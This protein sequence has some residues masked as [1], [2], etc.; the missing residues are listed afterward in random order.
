MN[1]N[2]FA[3]VATIFVLGLPL[4]GLVGCKG[5]CD[6]TANDSVSPLG[7][8]G[9][10]AARPSGCPDGTCE[11]DESCE[12]CSADCGKC[13]TPGF[14]K[15]PAGSFWMGSPGYGSCPKGYP[16]Y[17]VCKDEP[18]REAEPTREEWDGIEMLH[19]V[20]LTHDFEM[21]VTEVTVEE[22]IGAFG[23]PTQDDGWR[24]EWWAHYCTEFGTHMPVD[25]VSWSDA[26]AYANWKSIQ[27]GLKPCYR[28]GNVKCWAGKN[29]PDPSDY[30]YCMNWEQLGMDQFTIEVD[31][32][33]GSPYECEGFR[34]PTESEWEY[35]ARAG[36][37]SAYYD[38]LGSDDEH[39]ECEEPFHLTDI[40]WYCGNLR[41]DPGCGEPVSLKT[42]NAWGLFDMLGNSWE[43]CFDQM[44]YYPAGTL[45]EPDV[46]PFGP[47]D[48]YGWD[49][50]R[51]VRSCT[52]GSFAWEC[53][54]A[55]RIAFYEPQKSAGFRLARTLK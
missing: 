51:V 45:A 8:D 26:C 42:P 32:P 46:D 21:Q 14:V 6:C 49:D 1:V 38:G 24:T 30:L 5:E 34:L 16:G 41:P 22:W 3:L 29:P 54:S 7:E 19:Y 52:Y 36:T 44:G 53:R 17:P 28:F 18:G 35:A 27:Q 10:D 12:T 25:P 55:S 15:I 50:Y 23:P 9:G 13:V 20:V 11:P 37:I 4:P 47:R 39:L 33:S 48:A 31:T 40:A 43:W 2:Q